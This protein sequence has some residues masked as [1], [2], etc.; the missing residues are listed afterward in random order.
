LE[1]AFSNLKFAISKEISYIVIG[2]IPEKFFLDKTGSANHSNIN[3]A[4]WWA[5]KTGKKGGCYG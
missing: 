3:K 4:V 5:Y 1:W 2:N